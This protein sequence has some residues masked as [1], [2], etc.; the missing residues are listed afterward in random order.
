MEFRSL[1]RCFKCTY[2]IFNVFIN[3]CKIKREVKRT[4]CDVQMVLVYNILLLSHSYKFVNRISL[5]G[6][7]FFVF[8][9]DISTA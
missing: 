1:R 5:S 4:I 3:I 6:K 9:H 8:S 2:S 7:F